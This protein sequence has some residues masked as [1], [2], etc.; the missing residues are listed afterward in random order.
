MKKRQKFG[1]HFL[2]SKKIAESIV[3][4]ANLTRDDVVLEIGT[5]MG[6]LTPLLCE[7]SKKVISY[8]S[9]RKL[10]QLVKS[11]FK[12][13]SNLKL[14]YGDGFKCKENFSIFVSNL[15]YSQSRKAIEWL[16]QKKF[17]RGVIMM[18]KEF[19]EKLLTNSKKNRKAISVLAQHALD[20]NKIIKVHKSNFSPQP[21]VESVVL[22]IK[23]KT[24]VS[25]DLIKTINRLFS[26]RRKTLK[27]ILERFGKNIESTKRLD[28][29]NGDEII[30][31][32][33]QIIN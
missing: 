12:N 10:Y 20:I 23:R 9:D 32:A 5:G 30:K 11:R 1:Q 6:I 19:T 33:K 16:I 14:K 7:R 4:A 31:I 22:K 25:N 2:K 29:L 3:F 8:E 13:I 18:Q 17:S 24:T 21:K 27:N 15:P 26:Y 28:D